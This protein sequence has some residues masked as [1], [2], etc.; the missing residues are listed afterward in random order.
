[1]V[2]AKYWNAYVRAR[3]PVPTRR[4]GRGRPE[5]SRTFKIDGNAIEVWEC[6]ELGLNIFLLMRCESYNVVE[7]GEQR[8]V[9]VH[10]LT[11]TFIYEIISGSLDGE[12]V[13]PLEILW[14]LNGGGPVVESEAP[15][16]WL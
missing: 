10:A 13:A 14:D 15:D 7:S 1:M 2:I 4:K 8:F 3:E 11:T 5:D 12:H 16:L 6:T 9:F